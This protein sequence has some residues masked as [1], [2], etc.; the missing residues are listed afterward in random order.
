M[1]TIDHWRAS[2][3]Q[4]LSESQKLIAQHTHIKPRYAA[5][6]ALLWPVRQMP[7]GDE[8][9]DVLR[10]VLG[11]AFL[12]AQAFT[13]WDTLEKAIQSL[14]AAD[15][16]LSYK[17]AIDSLLRHFQADIARYLP[18]TSS[19]NVK[20]LRRVDIFISSP[21][22]VW[23]EREG[24]VRVLETLNSFRSIN[25]KYL[26]YPMLYEELVP[27]AVG[28]PAQT[29]V[30]RYMIE[31]DKV[32]LLICILWARMGTPFV[33]PATGERFASGTTYEFTKAYRAQKHGGQPH[34]LIYRKTAPKPDVDPQQQQAVDTFFKEFQGAEANFEGLYKT[35]DT[36]QTFESLLLKHVEQMLFNHPPALPA[37]ETSS[38]GLPPLPKIPAFNPSQPAA[39]NIQHNTGT[40]ITAQKSNIVTGIQDNRRQTFNMGPI[41]SETAIIGSTIENLTLNSGGAR[42]SEPAPSLDLPT[43]FQ[44]LKETLLNSPYADA[45]KIIHRA[46]HLVS[47]IEKGDK[48][49]RDSYYDLLMSM[50]PKV[51]TG[52]PAAGLIMQNMLKA[53]E[54]QL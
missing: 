33:D 4:T 2:I 44:Q 7:F 6:A 52:L 9:A 53:I 26:L 11:T 47:A 37:S 15:K 5:A 28:A 8:R 24:A 40:V 12:D 23:A 39:N 10:S 29:I 38:H 18:Q 1:P 31:P 48:D 45:A 20:M 41:H 19:E 22:D 17:E 32:F 16:N 30:D 51:K 27:P 49:T 50:L 36:T 13:G 3:P 42:A 43:L 25:E 34:I 46:E 54:N 35:F 14:E 21:S